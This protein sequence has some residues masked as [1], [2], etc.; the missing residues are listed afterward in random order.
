MVSLSWKSQIY[1]ILIGDWRHTKQTS[2]PF[3]NLYKYKLQ[4]EPPA[5]IQLVF[6]TIE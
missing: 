4:T 6:I 2:T 3:S 1:G 5:P